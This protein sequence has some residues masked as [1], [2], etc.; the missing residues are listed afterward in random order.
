VWGFKVHELVVREGFGVIRKLKKYGNVFVDLKLHD[1]PHTVELE[2]KTLVAYGA[3]IITVHASGGKEMLR[4]AVDAGG[5]KIAAVTVLTSLPPAEA[6]KVPHLAS[7]ARSA[8]ISTIVC[9]PR[10]V[11]ALRKLWKTARFITPGIRGPQDKKTDHKRT[12]TPEEALKR[13]ATLLVIGRPITKAPDV[14]QALQE[15]FSKN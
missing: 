11:G 8:G 12:S 2:V 6:R 15:L 5:D 3:D 4:A 10:E 7:L 13:G 9:S 14:G 1:I